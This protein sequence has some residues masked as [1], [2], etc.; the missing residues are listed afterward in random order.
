MAIPP[1]GTGTSTCTTGAGA[2][3]LT[4]GKPMCT[5]ICAFAANAGNAAHDTINNFP[6]VPLINFI[7]FLFTYSR[8]L[9][10]HFNQR[11]PYP[12]IRLS[13]ANLARPSLALLWLGLWFLLRLR[14]FWMLLVLLV[15]WQLLLR[16]RL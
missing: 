13:P 2:S 3:I 6:A 7:R 1:A 4:E 11:R 12:S 5:S 15:L 10:L 14:V 16:R 8:P 9:R